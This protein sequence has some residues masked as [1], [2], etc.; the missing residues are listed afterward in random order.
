MPSSRFVAGL[1]KIDPSVWVDR[2]PL[3]LYRFTCEGCFEPTTRRG[4]LR[5]GEGA[6][7]ALFGKI[8]WRTE[9]T[10]RLFRSLQ[11]PPTER[12][13]CMIRSSVEFCVKHGRSIFLR[14]VLSYHLLAKREGLLVCCIGGPR[15]F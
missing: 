7:H 8:D 11:W 9:T 10:V 3:S 15:V 5:L 4:S 6:T 12:R 13:F 14:V 1:G 2:S